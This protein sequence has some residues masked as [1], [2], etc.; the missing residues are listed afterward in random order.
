M[1]KKVDVMTFEDR[2]SEVKLEVFYAKQS[3]IK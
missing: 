1:N 3:T 2:E